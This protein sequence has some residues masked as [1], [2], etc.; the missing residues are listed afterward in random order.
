MTPSTFPLHGSCDTTFSTPS[1]TSFV[2]FVP[3]S[4][5]TAPVD[6]SDPVKSLTVVITSSDEGAHTL[7]EIAARWAG[8]GLLQESVWL[9]TDDAVIPTSGPPT[10]RARM[11]GG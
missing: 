2:R 11:L 10:V 4:S 6:G 3:L 7:R 8:Q 9:T 5:L 1:T